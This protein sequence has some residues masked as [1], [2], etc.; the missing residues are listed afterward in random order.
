MNQ[1]SENKPI[2]SAEK[3]HEL[4]SRLHSHCFV[5]NESNPTGLKIHFTLAADG[6]I[7]GEFTPNKSHEGYNGL[8]QGGILASIMDDAMVNCLF[9]YGVEALTAE[10]AVRYRKPV[11]ITEPIKVRAYFESSYSV[12]YRLR[13]ELTQ[14]GVVKAT[15]TSKFFAQK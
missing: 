11:S 2:G 14:G 7:E 1:M 6:A 4:Q 13:A 12:L 8:V 5:C 9:A 10:L 3:L 15:A